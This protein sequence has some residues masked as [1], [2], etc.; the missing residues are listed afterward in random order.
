MLIA[1]DQKK[2]RTARLLV[3]SMIDV[4]VIVL[5]IIERASI[6]IY[7]IEHRRMAWSGAN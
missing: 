4:L 6:G 5:W 3:V 1:Y 7:N 2:F